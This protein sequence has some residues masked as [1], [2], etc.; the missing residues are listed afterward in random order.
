V[1]KESY[2]YFSLDV[3]ICLPLH[4]HNCVENVPKYILFYVHDIKVMADEIDLPI[5][6][7]AEN[8]SVYPIVGQTKTQCHRTPITHYTILHLKEA[9]VQHPF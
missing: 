7:L 5:R 8:T 3:V 9:M 1:T 6:K 4:V 2:I